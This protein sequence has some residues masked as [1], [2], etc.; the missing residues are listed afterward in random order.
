MRISEGD[1]HLL[2]LQVSYSACGSPLHVSPA[3]RLTPTLPPC[4]SWRAPVLC[5]CIGT[6]ITWLLNARLQLPHVP[7]DVLVCLGGQAYPLVVLQYVLYR[8]V[9]KCSYACMCVGGMRKIT[10]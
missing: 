5:V 6:H 1:G 10:W 7:V 8:A 4:P 2:A 3:Q 9:C